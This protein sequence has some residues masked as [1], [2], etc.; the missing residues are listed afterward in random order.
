ME[1]FFAISSLAMSISFFGL[2]YDMVYGSWKRSR[3]EFVSDT[4]SDVSL[5]I[6]FIIMILIFSVAIFGLICGINNDFL[7]YNYTFVKNPWDEG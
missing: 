1:I 5:G 2:F 6:F 3:K 7:H 4:T